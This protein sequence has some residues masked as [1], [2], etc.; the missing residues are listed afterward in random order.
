MHTDSSLQLL[1]ALTVEFGKLLRQFRN[2]TCT[3]FATVE[4]PGE[5]AAR[6]RR[7]VAMQS[8]G[9]MASQ[10]DTE[11]SNPVAPTLPPAT[12]ALHARAALRRT[13]ELNLNIYKLH[14]LGDYVR[15][16]R[17]FGTTDSYSTQL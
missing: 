17:M 2:L 15:C 4:L 6:V 9:P 14:A 1:E 10:A 11:T 13:R 12:I 5:A 7:K 3:E 16:I 8:K